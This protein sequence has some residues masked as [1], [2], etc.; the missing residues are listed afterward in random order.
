M[1]FIVW[2]SPAFVHQLP[3]IDAFF[4]S[5]VEA[6]KWISSQQL[7]FADLRMTVGEFLSICWEK[8]SLREGDLSDWLSRNT[9]SWKSRPY[10]AAFHRYTIEERNDR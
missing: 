2:K 3:T 6:E 5:R 4:G 7:A 1:R 8:Y 9:A 10:V